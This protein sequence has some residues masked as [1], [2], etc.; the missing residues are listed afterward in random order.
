M[1]TGMVIL[2]ITS[3]KDG[4]LLFEKNKRIL[5]YSLDGLLL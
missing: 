4:G 2:L 5:L 3:E 1:V